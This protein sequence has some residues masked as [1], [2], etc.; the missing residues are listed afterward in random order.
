MIH[1]SIHS[2][3]NVS[4]PPSLP[5]SIHTIIQSFF[6]AYNNVI[7]NP[8]NNLSTHSL[9]PPSCYPLSCAADLVT[10]H[11]ISSRLWS[12]I[13]LSINPSVYLF[14]RSSALQHPD[15]PWPAFSPAPRF[16]GK[17]FAFSAQLSEHWSEV[18]AVVAF[19]RSVKT[20]SS[21]WIYSTPALYSACG[22]RTSSLNLEQEETW[23]AEKPEWPLGGSVECMQG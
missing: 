2:S 1:V 8:A 10:Q 16:V 22:L 5:P 11:A 20:Q 6:N 3:R 21:T 7:I 14:T 13:N 18:F 12:F 9:I 23:S 4:R 19:Y 17:T 15:S